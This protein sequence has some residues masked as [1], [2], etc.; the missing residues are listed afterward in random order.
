ML[1]DR[2]DPTNAEAL[3]DVAG[4]AALQGGSELA[5]GLA[6]KGAMRL[7]AGLMSSAV[8]P[9][10]ANTARAMMRGV[11]GE[12]LP[13]V[14]TLL[15]EKVNVTAGGLDKLHK[16]IKGTNADIKAI[17]ENTTGSVSPTSVATRTE[18]LA[19]DVAKQVDNESDVSAVKGV[20]ERFLGQDN[21]T[22]AAQVGTKMMDTGVLDASGRMVTRETPVMGRVSRPLSLVEAQELKQGTYK[23]LKDKAYGEMKGPAIEA[24]KA[25][26]RG[27][28]EEIEAE[29]KK[30]GIDL[31]KMNMREGNAIQTLEAVAKRLAAKGNSDPLA[32]AWLAN[33]SAAGLGLVASRSPG[34]K[35]LL[36]RGLYRPAALAANL[37]WL[38][39][40]VLRT[41]VQSV[42]SSSNQPEPK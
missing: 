31:G 29:A 21:T 24:N 30:A 39:P 27:L 34:V 37:P 32:L 18:Q 4:Q 2:P 15:E 5:G 22:K 3:Q 38:T 12:D 1:G 36:A 14:K 35:S 6:V 41:L 23:S 20:T 42:A 19:S 33:N 25:L 40:G 16:I 8:K 7:G 28:K 9:G 10:V 13:I 17:L 11:R 26:A